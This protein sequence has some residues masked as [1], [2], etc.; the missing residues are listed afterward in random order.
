M[1]TKILLLWLAIC[2][3]NFQLLADE[4]EKAPVAQQEFTE[5]E[6]KALFQL[7]ADSIEKTIK[8]KTG[9]I[10]LRGDLATIDVPK[11]F[12]YIDAANAKTILVDVWGNPPYETEDKP[13]GMLVQEN[14][15]LIGKDNSF[16]IEMTF[17]DDG[18]IKDD[19]AK[20]ID[21]SELL[22]SMQEDTK[23]ANDY[24]K[25]EGYPTVDFIGWASDPFYDAENKKLHWAKELQFEG[26]EINTLN[27]D[28]RV[29]GRKGFLKLTAISDMQTLANV[30]N[31]INPVLQSINFNEGHRYGDF[32]PDLDEVAAYGIGGLIAGK[33]LLKT[34]LIAKLGLV[35]AKSW[36]IILLAF[37]GLAGVFGKFFRRKENV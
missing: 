17:V 8:Y 30:K 35:L 27:Y 31:N 5:Q 4:T 29:L 7:Y 37:A 11:G 32:N 2:S 26:D 36:K 22:T 12:K 28:I 1:N 10:V 25:K 24:R 20:D 34:G 6:M 3:L 23:A 18:Y 33:V 21:Y 15:S 16:V 13:L 14:F 19:D 9:Q